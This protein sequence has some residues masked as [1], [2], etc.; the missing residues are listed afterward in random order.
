MKNIIAAITLV[1]V[2]LTG[3]S[4][5][6]ATDQKISDLEKRVDQLEK[7]QAKP[8]PTDFDFSSIGGRPVYQK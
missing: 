2:L 5:Q 6:S 4:H 1:L 7:Q 8:S 3:C